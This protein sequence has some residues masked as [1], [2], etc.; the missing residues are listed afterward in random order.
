MK[1]KLCGNNIP[2]KYKFCPTCGTP[3]DYASSTTESDV[4]SSNEYTADSEEYVS[5]ST[6]ESQQQE[7][8][9]ETKKNT[10]MNG[11]KYVIFVLLLLLIIN[12][13][14]RKFFKDN[15]QV[16]SS[17]INIETESINNN[18]LYDDK[19]KTVISKTILEHS[20]EDFYSYETL[21]SLSSEE[22]NNAIE[23][24][25][26][27]HG[28]NINDNNLNVFEKE[29]IRRIKQLQNGLK[30]WYSGTINDNMYGMFIGSDYIINI[31]KNDN[32][33]IV[34]EVNKVGLDT[35]DSVYF[36]AVGDSKLISIGDL[37]YTVEIISDDT[38]SFVDPKGLVD[39]LSRYIEA[40]SEGNV[41]N[42]YI[43][44]DCNTR[45]LTDNEINALTQHEARMAINEIAARHGRIF[46]D[47]EI[48]EYFSSKSW[49][50]PTLSK[51]EY[52][53]I[54]DNLLNEY[55][56]I[57]TERLIARKN[58]EVLPSIESIIN[59]R[60]D[61]IYGLYYN[62]KYQYYLEIVKDGNETIFNSFNLY[63][64][65]RVGN[66]SR[67][68][69]KDGKNWID[70]R[71]TSVSLDGK[72][73]LI[74]YYDGEF[75]TYKRIN[76]FSDIENSANDEIIQLNVDP[77]NWIGSYVGTGIDPISLI[78]KYGNSGS[79][80]F[81]CYF[82]AT[83]YNITNVPYT[84]TSLNGHEFIVSVGDISLNGTF[85]DNGE[86]EITWPGNN[87]TV[88]FIRN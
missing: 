48:N 87:E 60:D 52:D 47:S 15:S 54:S 56:Q 58:G 41:N 42:E 17:S 18:P 84:L 14:G 57:N 27:R 39:K 74:E 38:I 86:L 75:I 3:I 35:L 72:D 32:G 37:N 16:E 13:F 59:K 62:D 40:N 12:H 43:F 34:G 21:S 79:I 19:T 69:I 22:K 8:I 49:Y 66:D 26:L 46:Q 51:E 85:F 20:S 29:N 28:S 6:F 45:Y 24:I 25:Y 7:T 63:D 11:W 83:G 9:K 77:S 64:G 73:T 65:R 5:N 44:Y 67:T 78:V 30:E 53:H 80:V 68:A 76:D 88:R 2:S 81:D 23:E 10:K 4:S 1:C 82:G 33:N 71:G 70:D 36:Y 55:E 50:K 31:Y 61:S